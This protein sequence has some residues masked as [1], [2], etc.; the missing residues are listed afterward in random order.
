MLPTILN[1]HEWA[2][3]KHF[4]YFNLNTKTAWQAG[5]KQHT[6]TCRPSS[7]LV[8]LS[9]PKGEIDS[10][11]PDKSAISF[12]RTIIKF[13]FLAINIKKYEEN[14]WKLSRLYDKKSAM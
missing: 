6:R 13:V 9:N 14:T 11:T 4:V 8:N 5:S 1:L 10:V 2:R 3:K 12:Y 7:L